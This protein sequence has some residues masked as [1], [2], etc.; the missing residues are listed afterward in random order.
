M[1]LQAELAFHTAREHLNFGKKR[2]HFG[3]LPMR[4]ACSSSLGPTGLPRSN[5]LLYLATHRADPHEHILLY[6]LHTRV[7]ASNK[8]RGHIFY[9]RGPLSHLRPCCQDRCLDLCT[10]RESA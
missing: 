6:S 8:I 5:F 7:R 4:T 9:L 3:E 1:S 2:L 10:L